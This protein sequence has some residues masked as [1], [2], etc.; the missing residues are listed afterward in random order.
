[1]GISQGRGAASVM[2]VRNWDGACS[3]ARRIGVTESAA[4]TLKE[5]PWPKPWSR[6]QPGQPNHV[7]LNVVCS[8]NDCSHLYLDW[9]RSLLPTVSGL[10]WSKAFV[11]GEPATDS[12]ARNGF[13][14]RF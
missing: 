14:R 4:V 5:A 6:H 1:M 10:G 9:L 12:D 11:D 3:P 13:G 8:K 7:Y 2:A